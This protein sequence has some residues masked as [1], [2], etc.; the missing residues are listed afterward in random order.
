[1]KQADIDRIWYGARPAPW[2]MCALV[3]LYGWLYRLVRWPYAFGWRR[4]ARLPLPLIMV[5]N[6][7]AGGAGKTPLVMA[8]IDALRSRGLTPGVVSRGY[9]GSATAPTL[10]DEAPDPRVVGDE[11]A[12]IRRRTGAAVAVGRDRVAA[13]GLLQGSGI[14]VIIADDG[15]QNPALCRD[16]E[17]CV[18]DGQRRFGNG[19]L[20]PAGPLREPASRLGHF[21]FVVCNGGSA[22][23]GEI[24]MQLQPGQAI[25]VGHGAAPRSLASFADGKVHAVA[26]IGNPQRF[27]ASL[28][29]CGLD[30]I[31][32]PFADHHA[33]SASDFAFADALPVL[34]TEKD[35]V[36][37]LELADARFW[38]VPVDAELPASFFDAVA[39]RL[40]AL[41]SGQVDGA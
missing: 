32:H 9:G 11:P 16:I 33:F 22:Q 14:D 31:E 15:L 12:L 35:A 19:R 38:Q 6:L 3:P 1:M 28:R 17:I 18:V 27:F 25:P 37:C 20:L 24:Q 34:M 5:G 29:A 26:G 40:A 41:H 8:L 39:R 23:P 7:T 2:W 36:K 30:I 21:D 4:P 10:L 13:A